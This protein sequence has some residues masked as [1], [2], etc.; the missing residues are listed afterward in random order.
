M[1]SDDSAFRWAEAEKDLM[2]GIDTTVPHS[3]RIWNYWLGG[4]D[5][6]QVDREAGD[7]FCEIY[8]GIVDDALAYREF[9]ARVVRYLAGEASI[10]QFLDV[11][12]GLPTAD[13]THEVAQRVAPT[14]RIVYVDNDPLVLIH[15]RALL[16]S[17]P[18]GVTRYV[19]A[20]LHDPDAIIGGAAQILDFSRPIGITMM[21]ILGHITDY[22][23][24]KSIVKRLL[25][26]VPSGSYLAIAD[27]LSGVEPFDAAMA[28]WNEH[29]EPKYTLRSL[30]QITGYFDGLELLEPGVVPNPLWRPDPSPFEPSAELENVG[31]VGR[32]P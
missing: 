25:D 8:P 15:A 28:I 5:N 27:G 7:A 21:G 11:G 23:E 24:A 29:A 26:A 6:Y 3:A 22:A 17:T 10:R 13:N 20:D 12:T 14:S 19:D 2:E 32:K 16:T 30:Q 31:G 18:E 9:L 1:S 4:K